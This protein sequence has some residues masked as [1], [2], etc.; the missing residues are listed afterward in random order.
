MEVLKT[1]KNISKFDFGHLSNIGEEKRMLKKCIK[2][3]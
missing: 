3:N 2:H 1:P